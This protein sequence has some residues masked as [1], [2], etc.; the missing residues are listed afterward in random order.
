MTTFETWLSSAS[1]FQVGGALVVGM[2]AAAGVGYAMRVQRDRSEPS[3]DSSEAQQ[4]YIFSA[5]LG[6]LALLLGFT[7]ALATER[8][9]T[10]R[11]MVLEEANAIRTA[12]LQAQLLPEPH[13]SR[14][15]AA[16]ARYTDHAIILAQAGPKDVPKL[17]AEDDRLLT[18]LWAAAAAGFDSVRDIDFSSTLAASV[19]EVERM[20][21]SR[22]AAR[23]SHVPGAVFAVLFLYLTV[24]AG[25]LGYVLTGAR[26]RL[27]GV[28]LLSLMT[29]S[30][31]LVLDIDR[32]TLGHIRE[33]QG[34]MQDV[35]A[36]MVRAPPPVFDRYRAPSTAPPMQPER[37]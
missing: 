34:P 23:Q 22:R 36:D 24:T 12:Y 35:Q 31:M 32:P 28:F 37:P 18:D 9:D 4:G 19:S 15:G 1:T 25:M 30:L 2:A 26:G 17:V 6:L 33:S 11:G 10:R 14:L 20:D 7:F 21:A 29:L 27:S 13:R 3:R 8:F 5:V 16:L